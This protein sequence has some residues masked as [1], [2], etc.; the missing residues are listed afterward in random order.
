DLKRHKTLCANPAP[1]INEARPIACDK[2]ETRNVILFPANGLPPQ[3][4]AVECRIKMSETWDG[5]Q[6][7]LLNLSHILGTDGSLCGAVGLTR[8]RSSTHHSRL[9]LERV[10][11]TSQGLTENYCVRR[12]TE[13]HNDFA[14]YGNVVGIRRREPPSKYIQYLDVTD[15]DIASFITYFQEFGTRRAPALPDVAMFHFLV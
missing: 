11:Q 1:V 3:I 14:W 12:I 4:I 9:Y 6:E 7:E 10:N 13:G 2:L 15:Q 5:L 8:K